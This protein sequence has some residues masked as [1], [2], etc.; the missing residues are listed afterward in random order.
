MTYFQS[1]WLPLTAT[2]FLCIHKSWTRNLWRLSIELHLIWQLYS[3]W[4][5]RRPK[6]FL[7]WGR[8]LLQGIEKL[9][10]CVFSWIPWVAAVHHASLLQEALQCHGR[11]S[12]SNVVQKKN[13]LKNVGITFKIH[14]NNL[15]N[16]C[17]Q[18][19]FIVFP[20][21]TSFLWNILFHQ[22]SK[23]KYI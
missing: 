9:G 21:D 6:S 19:L 7:L 15:S 12:R 18:N 23:K 3:P 17:R 20:S 8:F 1:A 22:K 5:C 16:F 11:M 4:C 10:R 2:E 13:P 14:F